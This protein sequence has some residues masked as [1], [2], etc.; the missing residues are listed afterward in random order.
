MVCERGKSLLLSFTTQGC[1]VP[2]CELVSELKV[3]DT[4]L[5]HNIIDL[6]TRGQILIKVRDTAMAK[7]EYVI[8]EQIQFYHILSHTRP[9]IRLK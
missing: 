7:A 1:P 4:L 8:K 6:K 3:L 2:L 5:K 9:Y